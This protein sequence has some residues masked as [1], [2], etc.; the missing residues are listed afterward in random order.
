VAIAIGVANTTAAI[1]RRTSFLIARAPQERS[2][3]RPP[4]GYARERRNWNSESEAG[5]AESLG[6]YV[7]PRHTDYA[8]PTGQQVKQDVAVKTLGV[9]HGS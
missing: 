9:G 6:S 8:F 3:T 5:L 7:S 4:S 2:L 1:K